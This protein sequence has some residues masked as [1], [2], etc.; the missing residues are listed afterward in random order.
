MRKLKICSR[1]AQ[2]YRRKRCDTKF[3]QE[4]ADASTRKACRATGTGD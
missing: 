1:I 2:D 4:A 3:N